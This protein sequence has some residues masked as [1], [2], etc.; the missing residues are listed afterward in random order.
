MPGTRSRRRERQRERASLP[1]HALGDEIPAHGAREIAADREAQSH[2]LRSA[3]RRSA[4]PARTARRSPTA[5]PPG[6]RARVADADRDL[7]AGP[8][9]LERDLAVRLRELDRV[10]HQ[11]RRASAPPSHGP[12][13]HA[14]RHRNCGVRSGARAR[15]AAVRSTSSTP[16]IASAMLNSRIS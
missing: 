4:P 1:D 14:G 13:E 12:R 5:Y 6:C 16:R 7:V 11:V 8:L 10:R 3:L 2:A 15:E 9:A